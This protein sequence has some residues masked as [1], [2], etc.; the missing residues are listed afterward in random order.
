MEKV[1]VVKMTKSDTENKLTK[2]IAYENGRLIEQSR[3]EK[4]G[5]S[6]GYENHRFKNPA[7]PIFFHL[8]VRVRDNYITSNDVFMGGFTTHWHENIEILHVISGKLKV[9]CGDEENV[10]LPGET[11]VINQGRFHYTEALDEKAE[12]YCLIIG[13]DF[14]LEKG[15]NSDE[16]IFKWKFKDEEVDMY[17]ANIEKTFK[18]KKNELYK[19]R[20]LSFV[21]LIAEKLY[22]YYRENENTH[23]EKESASMVI[24]KQVMKYINKNFGEVIDIGLIAEKLGVS[25][26]HMCHCFKA[27]TGCGVVEFANMYKIERAKALICNSSMNVS[28]AAEYCGFSSLSYFTRVFKKYTG[29]LP[30]QIKNA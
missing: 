9:K 1:G 14:L 19:T 18:E 21:T 8:D 27:C 24:C 22:T 30:S 28:E 12:Y 2:Q 20:I 17:F 4:A 25:K 11:A 23:E 3:W 26:F 6:F 15:I 13:R 7:F 29:V 5:Y 10:F 16:C